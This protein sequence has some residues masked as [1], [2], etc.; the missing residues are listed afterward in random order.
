[1]TIGDRPFSIFEID[2]LV[3]SSKHIGLSAAAVSRIARARTIVEAY[4]AG[5]E[6]VYGLNTGLGGNIAFRIEPEA[7]QA[8]QNQLVI[9]RNI[10]VGDP[11]TERVVVPSSSAASWGWLPAAQ[12]CP[13][14]RC[15]CSSTCSTPA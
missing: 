9:G 2:D 8:F 1:M 13:Q 3:A 6:P 5:N 4:A 14:P 7:I 15:G 12:A 10:G 11:L